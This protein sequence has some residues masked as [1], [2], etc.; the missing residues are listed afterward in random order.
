MDWL[1]NLW[2]TDFNSI[3]I[4]V[5]TGFIFFVLSSI[6][7]WFSGGKIRQERVSKAKELLIDIIEGMIVNQEDITN[8]KLR[9]IFNA[10]EREVNI[11]IDAAYDL[12][13]LFEDVMLRFQRSKHL[14]AEQKDTYSKN[15]SDL[16]LSLALEVESKENIRV[17]PR[18][19]EKIFV[20]IEENIEG[21][22][23][24]KK[25]IEELKQKIYRSFP[26]SNPIVNMLVMYRRLAY[27]KPGIFIAVIVFYI[28]I[29]LI[30][31]LIIISNELK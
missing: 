6:G 7:I 10:V 30:I 28:I 26:S 13:E 22:L 18:A 15:L 21:N 5:I 2:D 17:I 25:S 19:Y 24:A 23:D 3:V 4:S 31:M 14:S 29:M 20:E 1:A 12:E 27:E 16:S 9:K 8:I 11:S